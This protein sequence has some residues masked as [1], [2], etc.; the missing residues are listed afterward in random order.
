MLEELLSTSFVPLAGSNCMT[1]VPDKWMAPLTGTYATEA[2][3]IVV[4]GIMYAAG[5]SGDVFAF[6]AKTGLPI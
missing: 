3:P 6:D 1:F 2:T 4:D 5:G